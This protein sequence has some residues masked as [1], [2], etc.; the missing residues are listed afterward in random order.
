MPTGHLHFTSWN[1]YPKLKNPRPLMRSGIFWQRMRDSNPVKKSLFP[2]WHKD[3]L[4]SV[5]I[6]IAIFGFLGSAEM[7]GEGVLIAVFIPL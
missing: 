1:P 7:G 3:F 4:E 2:L 6:F 5:A